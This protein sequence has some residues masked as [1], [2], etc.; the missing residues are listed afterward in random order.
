MVCEVQFL[1]KDMIIAKKRGH[2]IYE[3]LRS[4]P[5]RVNVA[6]FSNLY[7]NPSVEIFAILQKD[8]YGALATFILN[9][10]EFE[11]RNRSVSYGADTG[12]FCNRVTAF[13]ALLAKGPE[14]K[15]SILSYNLYI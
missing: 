11:Y 4:K 14:N 5:F 13:E 15:L 10:P 6:K 7:S 9:H 2:S 1:L 3:V 8:D 12:F